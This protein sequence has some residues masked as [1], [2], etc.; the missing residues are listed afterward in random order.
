MHTEQVIKRNNCA[1][2]YKS[3][4]ATSIIKN[5]LFLDAFII[6]RFFGFFFVRIAWNIYRGVTQKHD[7]ES[8]PESIRFDHC[9][10]VFVF[11][12]NGEYYS[13]YKIVLRHAWKMVR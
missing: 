3:H 5:V 2:Y 6:L 7:C 11:E 1:M 13:K 9:E 10:Q 4:T 12:F 8:G